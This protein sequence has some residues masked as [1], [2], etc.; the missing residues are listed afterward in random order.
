[1]LRTLDYQNGDERPTEPRAIPKSILQD[2]A[3]R[4]AEGKSKGNIK[5]AKRVQSRCLRKE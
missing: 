2:V 4:C 5:K 3:L 1:M